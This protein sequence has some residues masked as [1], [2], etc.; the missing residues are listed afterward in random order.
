MNIQSAEQYIASRSVINF[1]TTNHEPTIDLSL[2]ETMELDINPHVRFERLWEQGESLLE[3]DNDRG[4]VVEARGLTETG[5]PLSVKLTFRIDAIK[6]ESATGMMVCFSNRRV[7][8]AQCSDNGVPLVPLEIIKETETELDSKSNEIFS[9]NVSHNL[10]LV[11]QSIMAYQSLRAQH[12]YAEQ[13]EPILVE[14]S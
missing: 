2:G 12:T 9:A 4:G 5:I 6:P 8:E 3:V 1:A 13:P 10:L 11:E 7:I 14:G